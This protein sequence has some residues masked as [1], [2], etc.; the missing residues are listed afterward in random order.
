MILKEHI[1]K[2][3]TKTKNRNTI[4]TNQYDISMKRKQRYFVSFLKQ[5]KEKI[6]Y[7]TKQNI[8]NKKL[9]ML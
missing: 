1:N 3:I 4:L 7:E 8:S 2:S 6:I 5:K 9:K